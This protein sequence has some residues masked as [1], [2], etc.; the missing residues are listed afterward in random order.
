MPT[1]NPLPPKSSRKDAAYSRNE[2]TP[3]GQ[4]Y[5]IDIARID[6]RVPQQRIDG[7]FDSSQIVGDPGFKLT[8]RNGNPQDQTAVMEPELRGLVL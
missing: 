3:S 6:A 7:S 2:G 4:K 5:T 8:A 1:A